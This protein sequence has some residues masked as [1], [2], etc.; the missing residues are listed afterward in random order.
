[1]NIEI[2]LGA[3]LRKF[4][5][6]MPPWPSKTPAKENPSTPSD[7][8]MMASSIS[9]RGPC[10]LADPQRIPATSVK[11][12][13]ASIAIAEHWLLT[14]TGRKLFL[15]EDLRLEAPQWSLVR[16]KVSNWGLSNAIN[17]VRLL[18][19]NEFKVKYGGREERGSGVGWL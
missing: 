16:R 5:E 17:R 15:V 9:S 6:E 3:N 8:T 14:L 10:K 4:T 1:M 2:Q 19:W 13:G 12:D 7:R 11:E 18:S